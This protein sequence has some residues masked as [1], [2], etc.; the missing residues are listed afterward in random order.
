MTNEMISISLEEYEELKRE[1]VFLECLREA[2]VDNW[3]GY[4]Y[5]VELYRET[6]ECI[7]EE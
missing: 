5:A 6:P 4:E 1:Q 7:V 3:N 2:G